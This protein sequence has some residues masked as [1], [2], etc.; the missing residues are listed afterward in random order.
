MNGE[1]QLENFIENGYWMHGNENKFLEIFLSG[2]AP[3][4]LNTANLFL[5][6][7]FHSV[8]PCVCRCGCVC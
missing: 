7:L 6:G 4:C 8:I 5:Y 3:F 1:D 2:R